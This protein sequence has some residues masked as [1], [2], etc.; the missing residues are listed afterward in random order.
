MSEI[1]VIIVGEVLI[2]GISAVMV[3]RNGKAITGVQRLGR[4]IIY[5][6]TINVM[7]IVI[8]FT[9]DKIALQ[10]N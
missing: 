6:L 7:L 4:F 1:V 3:F 2:I 8:M 9:V 5:F 10:L